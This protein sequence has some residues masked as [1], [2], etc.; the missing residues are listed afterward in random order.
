MHGYDHPWAGGAGKNGLNVTATTT[1][2][3][4]VTFTVNSDGTVTANGTATESITFNLTNGFIPFPSGNYIINGGVDNNI[5]VYANPDRTQGYYS[6]GA[7][8]VAFN[9]STELVARIQIESGTVCNNALIKPMIRLSTVTDSAFAPYS[10]IC[11]ISGRTES[12]VIANGKNRFDE[13]YSETADIVYRSIY[14]G[15]GTFTMSTDAPLNTG[16]G[17][18]LFFFAGQVTSGASTNNN[19]VYQSTSRTVTAVDGYVT[20]A[21]RDA[22]NVNPANY[23]TQI[24]V[25]TVA[26]AYVPYSGRNT[27]TISFGTTVYGGQVDFKTGNVT[28]EWGYIASYNGETLPG[29]WISDRDVYA[30]GTTPTTDAEVCYELATPT[31]LSL[32]PDILTMLKNNNSVS[33][34]GVITITALTGDSWS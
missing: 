19:G 6:G 2:D 18:N 1:T 30:A 34:D 4:G 8:S 20:V 28:V 13:D 24:E 17:S 9:V 33:G 3:G 22:N 23:H 27:A 11:P 21:Y 32:T 29:A 26:T 16:G 5:R 12:S 25:G 10:N 31:T 14:V 7:D 15:D